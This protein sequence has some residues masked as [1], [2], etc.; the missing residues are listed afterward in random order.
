MVA[1]IVREY[2]VRSRKYESEAMIYCKRFSM[3]SLTIRKNFSWAY[4]RFQFSKEIKNC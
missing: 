2:S 3:P 4:N 1:Q